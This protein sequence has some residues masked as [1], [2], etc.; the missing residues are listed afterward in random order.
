VAL[1][2]PRNSECKIAHWSLGYIY[3]DTFGDPIC[4]MYEGVPCSVD[5][6]MCC[7]N[8]ARWCPNGGPHC[9]RYDRGAYPFGDKA[10]YANQMTDPVALSPFPNAILWNWATILVMAFGNLGAL[11]LEA[12][13]L[14][15]K[16]PSRC[17]PSSAKTDRSLEQISGSHLACTLPFTV[18]LVRCSTNSKD[19]AAEL[20]PCWLLCVFCCS[21]V[22]IFGVYNSVRLAPVVSCAQ[23]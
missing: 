23:V 17:I 1:H 8:Q 9:D 14:A 22:C 10:V 18:T 3:P 20:H 16:T 19:S 7:Y 11:D 21:S 6:S 15:G 5:P 12:R 13:C 4:D 2:L